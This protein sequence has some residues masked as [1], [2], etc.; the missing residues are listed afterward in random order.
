MNEDDYW[1]WD[2]DGCTTPHDD[3]AN[4]P[5]SGGPF[6]KFPQDNDSENAVAVLM[7]NYPFGPEKM[8]VE[9]IEWDSDKDREMLVDAYNDFIEIHMRVPVAVFSSKEKYETWRE[10]YIGDKEI[11]ENWYTEMRI[12]LDN[13]PAMFECQIPHLG[14]VSSFEEGIEK[15]KALLDLQKKEE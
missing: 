6:H 12:P 1:T 14:V 4:V 11:P 3:E 15:M 13:G 5:M 9:D 8:K 2:E 7:H 10:K